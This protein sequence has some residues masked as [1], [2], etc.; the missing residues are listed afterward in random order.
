MRLL[1]LAL[2]LSVVG[3]TPEKKEIVDTAKDERT[4][5]NLIIRFQK[6]LKQAYYGKSVNTDSLFA[7]LFQPDVYYVTYWG[8]TEP[9][10]ST[11]LRVRK[12]IP[13]IKEYEYRLEGLQVKVFGDGAYA[14]FI[15]RQTYTLNGNLM[16]EYL[17]TTYIFE[18]KEEGW[19]VAHVHR[20]ADLQTIQHL[21][22][23]AQQR[24]LKK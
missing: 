9:I 21:M 18:R 20:S 13:L 6:D 23:I 2:I 1:I 11:K 22:A 10:D 12:A 7:N 19:K 8:N 16:D 17:P 4:I 3:C 24:E 5:E 14:F 15:L